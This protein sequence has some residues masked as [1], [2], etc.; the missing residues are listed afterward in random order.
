MKILIFTEQMRGAI[1]RLFISIPWSLCFY[2]LAKLFDGVD[3]TDAIN[4]IAL[5][6]KVRGADEGK[7]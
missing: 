1:I 6:V 4:W 2:L 7:D 5:A 3:D